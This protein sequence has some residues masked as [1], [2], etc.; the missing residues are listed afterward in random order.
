MLC[1]IDV[2]RFS[3]K[4]VFFA[5][6]I[7]YMLLLFTLLLPPCQ[8]K[9]GSL[10]VGICTAIFPG[11]HSTAPFVLV[12]ALSPIEM[13]ASY[14]SVLNLSMVI[15]QIF[16]ALFAAALNGLGSSP[17]LTLTIAISAAMGLAID[18]AVVAVDCASKDGIPRNVLASR[19]KAQAVADAKERER[20]T[21][22][23]NTSSSMAGGLHRLHDSTTSRP[24]DTAMLDDVDLDEGPL[25][26]HQV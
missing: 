1:V 13:R 23:M 4:Y 9:I 16:I 20:K 21:S 5:G 10:V 12:E 26:A 14:I 11:I 17:N 18:I 3:V 15:S 25:L 24:D 7:L 6:E 22:S 19:I 8:T 2:I